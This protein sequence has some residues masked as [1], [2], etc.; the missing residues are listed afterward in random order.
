M[1]YS[2]GIFVSN[3]EQFERM[4][5]IE[6]KNGRARGAQVIELENSNALRIEVV[7]DRALDI[8]GASWLGKNL[9]WLSPTGIVSSQN[10]NMTEIPWLNNWSGGLI[11]TGGLDHAL[12]PD[13]DETTFNY[14]LLKSRDFPIH[15]R[16]SYQP[17]EDFQFFKLNNQEDPLFVV[18]GQVKQVTVFGEYLTL[19]RAI[20]LG[21]NNNLISIFDE[22]TNKGSENTDH[23]FL[24]HC[25]FGWP[26]I[27][28]GVAINRVLGGGKV[29]ELS[30]IKAPEPNSP[31]TVL[32]EQL[33]TNEEFTHV[34]IVNEIIDIEMHHVFSN[35]NFNFHLQWLVSRPDFMVYGSEASTNDLSGRKAAREKSLLK[36]LKHGEK[37]EYDTHFFVDTVG[38]T[39][40]TEIKGLIQTRTKVWERI[41][42][43][44]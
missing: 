41:K 7:A 19:E 22:V 5:L 24:Y 42:E 16:I 2:K 27:Q 12:G 21:R 23:M 3:S 28:P 11:T 34:N 30:K 39:S 14:P 40:P 1:I 4:R 25:N 44:S 18:K 26:L 13:T 43:Q 20:L 6:L 33:N 38:Q 10:L 29:E 32:V 8:V 15:G 37:F 9:A 17:A 31:E 35:K 36:N